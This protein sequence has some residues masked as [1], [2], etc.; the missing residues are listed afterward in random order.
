MGSGKTS[1]GRLAARSMGMD[2]TDTDG[3]IIGTTGKSIGEIFA[4][5][6]EEHFRRLER[7]EVGKVARLDKQVIATGGG[8]VLDP[9]NMRM[10]RRN[11]L[12]VNLTARPETLLKRLKGLEDRPLMSSEDALED[13]RRHSS[14][15]RK[16]YNNADFIINTESKKLEDVAKEVCNL[17]QRPRIRLCVSV[18]GD[19]P[20]EQVAA[21][22]ESGATMVEL[23]LDLI[24]VPDIEGLVSGSGLPVI[25][26]DRK[27]KANLM[28]AIEAGCDYVDIELDA[29][30]RREVTAKA[31]RH[32]VKVI[33]SMHDHDRT[34]ERFPDKGD[35]D[36]LKI[37]T[38]VNGKED[39]K[40]LVCQLDGR[41]DLIVVGMGELGIPSRIVAPLLGSYL[42][43]CTL[44]DGT[45]PGQLRLGDMQAAYRR[46]GLR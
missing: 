27:D 17:A 42:T 38:K 15:R 9:A 6:G 16:L 4:E 12:I 24:R 2:F 8:V 19:D 41:D 36:L 32:G 46:M 5:E 20:E 14:G 30:E 37:A 44:S 11:G 10:L 23:R 28:T 33:A 45:A 43:Y 3:N 31:R 35:A 22:A 39:L 29:A 26:T 25:A 34:P 7:A 21:A 40:K 1:V 18:S 13:I